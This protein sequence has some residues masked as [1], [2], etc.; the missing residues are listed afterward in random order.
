MAKN[1]NSSALLLL[2]LGGA[3]IYFLTRDKDKKIVTGG[4]DNT[5]N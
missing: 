3:G 5:D 4:S 2:L 1:D